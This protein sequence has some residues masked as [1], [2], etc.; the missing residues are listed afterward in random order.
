MRDFATMLRTFSVWHYVLMSIALLLAAGM[1]STFSGRLYFY[2]AQPDFLL[3]TAIVIGVQTNSSIGTIAGFLVGFLM[4]GVGG[5]YAGT[6]IISRTVATFGALWFTESFLRHAILVSVAATFFG[7]LFC[8][9]LFGLSVPNFGIINLLKMAGI[10]AIM[11][12]LLAIPLSFLFSALIKK[13][14]SFF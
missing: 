9:V 3:T 7:T 14:Q 1:Q 12:T 6:Y 11:N 5:P 2:G 4:A 8:G 10:G 13:K